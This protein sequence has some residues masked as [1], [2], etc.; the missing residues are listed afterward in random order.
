M[1]GLFLDDKSKSAY[2]FS[3]YP[4]V[5]LNLSS[6]FNKLMATNYAVGNY[7]G[8]R[9]SLTANPSYPRDQI[10]SANKDGMFTGK[11]TANTFQNLDSAKV[12]EAARWVKTLAA[13]ESLISVGFGITTNFNGKK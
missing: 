4:T 1:S 7:Y 12:G 5:N 10:K 2:P 13:R 11:L 8:L 6:G 3:D 9:F